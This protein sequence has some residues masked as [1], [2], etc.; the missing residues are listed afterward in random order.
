LF[1]SDFNLNRLIKIKYPEGTAYFIGWSS[2]GNIAW[3]NY[4][5][6]CNEKERKRSVCELNIQSMNSDSIIYH[7]NFDNEAYQS[8]INNVVKNHDNDIQK[9]L[10]KYR[11]FSFYGYIDT[12]KSF[13]MGNI[14]YS[15]DFF[16]MKKKSNIYYKEPGNSSMENLENKAAL[17]V[18][19]KINGPK[20]LFYYNKKVTDN[21]TDIDFKGWI[22]S[23]FEQ[24]ILFLIMEDN[25]FDYEKTK[26]VFKGYFP[27]K[28]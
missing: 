19:S 17:S 2:S 23:P 26:I 27:A 16:S 6:V 12:T 3:L 21:I 13:T 9:I 25:L 8:D 10:T 4:Y 7:L 15:I 11:I 5:D 20:L 24:R 1:S 28:K 22:K 14:D 18:N